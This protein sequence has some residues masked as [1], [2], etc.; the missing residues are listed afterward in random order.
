MFGYIFNHL[1]PFMKIIFI[2]FVYYCIYIYIVI[3]NNKVYI[4]AHWN[5]FRCK[6]YIIPITFLFGRPKGMNPIDSTISNANTCFW[7]MANKLAVPKFDFITPMLKGMLDILNSLGSSMDSLKKMVGNLFKFLLKIAWDVRNRLE[8][9]QEAMT[10]NF[11]KMYNAFKRMNS[12]FIMNMFMAE[13][14][15][16]SLSSISNSFIK[17][18]ADF[19]SDVGVGMTYFLFG[20]L[21]NKWFPKLVNPFKAVCFSG[22]T[23]IVMKDLSTVT[24]QKLYDNNTLG[25]ILYGNGIIHSVLK[26][27]IEQTNRKL[28]KYNNI[29][30]SGHHMVYEKNIP[31]RIKDSTHSELIQTNEDFIYCLITSNRKVYIDNQWF[32]DFMESNDIET[33]LLTYR[34]IIEQLNQ[35]NKIVITDDD[36]QHLYQWGL[37]IDTPIKMKDGSSKSIQDIEIGNIISTGK[38][39]GKIVHYSKPI[40]MYSYHTYLL[41]GSQAVYEN[42][43]WIRIHQSKYSIKVNYPFPEIYSITTQTNRIELENGIIITDYFEV[44]DDSDEIDHIHDMNLKSMTPI[45]LDC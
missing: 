39:T 44:N 36:R 23:P 29:I 6:P 25:N 38:V 28:Y 22:I 31:I 10:Y 27:S 19:A 26:F 13:A 20:P 30:V 16:T 1:K 4:D 41:S 12:S 7:E 5:E 45:I 21:A 34:F 43:I 33:T 32:S 9:M 3:K 17:G 35:T 42:G 24:I 11:L 40:Q 14:L 15:A 37:A 8:G 18:M 2:L